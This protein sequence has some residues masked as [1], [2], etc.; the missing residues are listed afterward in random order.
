MI[1]IEGITVMSQQHNNVGTKDGEIK[2]ERRKQWGDRR[3]LADRRNPERQLHAG[4]D[5]RTGA[6]RRKSDLGGD[7]GDGEVWWRHEEEAD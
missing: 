5:C 6:P 2:R 7:L 3:M 1:I 4:F